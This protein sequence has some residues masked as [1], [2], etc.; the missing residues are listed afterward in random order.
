MLEASLAILNANVITLNSKQ[1]RAQ[2]IA[3]H[4]GKIV[5][6]GSDQ[7][8]RQFAG[9]N[10]KVI[11]MKNKTIVPGLVDC[12]VHMT[13]FGTFLQTLDLRNVKSIE[14]MQ[15]KLREHVRAHPNAKWIFEG[16]WDQEKFAENRYPTR[17]D[18]DAAVPNKPVFLARVCGHVGVANSKALQL[19]SI[20]KETT[21]EGGQVELDKK[22][23]EPN[24]IL[25]ENAM[26]LV[27]QAIPK[28]NLKT[29]ERTCL[30]A[31]RK[32]V[33][34]GLT[35]VHW[36]V[37]S[38]DEICTLQKMAT[39]K[40]LPLRVYLG[41]NVELLE[42][43][44]NPRT[45]IDPR[46]DMLKIGFVKILADGSL[47]ARTAALKQP[48]DD[49]R[50]TLGMMLY[51]QKKLNQLVLKAHQAG[52]QLGIHAIGDR[53]VDNVITAFEKALKKSPRKNHR[54]RIE[55]C[56]L[57]DP[58][59][60]RRM[61]HLKLI[62][63]VQPHFVISDFWTVDRIGKSRA[64]WTYPFKTL[65]D[66]GVVV[67]SSSDCPIEQINPLLGI[68]AG[69]TRKTGV[70][71]RLTVEEMLRTYTVNAAY[72]SFDEEKKGTIEVGKLADLTVLSEDITEIIPDKI[73]D[74]TVQ[75]VIVDG[76]IV[77]DTE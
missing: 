53:A 1:P 58:N 56:S 43:I 31:C 21:V 10:T 26:E 24:G 69:V 37:N 55:H 40:K 76:K 7:Q 77:Y 5:A 30:L 11:H 34:E 3:I 75:M 4:E 29:L 17:W 16:R 41:V 62:A 72:A 45:L 71:E 25:Y 22:T 15:N 23:N 65:T 64:R 73:R 19:A 44:I 39:E 60:I 33:E 13:E 12:H 49:N 54:H 28:P 32:A 63:S 38:M 27:K 70:E 42:E 61:K 8:I 66:A 46:S 57:L 6:V 36:L 59:L 35:T 48:Y 68:W 20:T 51:T 67:A 18:L 74:V 2:A 9:K 14:E 52:L 47:G 50:S